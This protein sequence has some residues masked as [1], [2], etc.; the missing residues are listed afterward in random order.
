MILNKLKI[1]RLIP[2]ALLSCSAS[3]VQADEGGVSF[4]LPGQYSSLAAA[5][6]QQGW[7]L[8]LIYYH[9]SQ[10]AQ[11][12]QEIPAAGKVN[13]GLDAS[14]DLLLAVPSYAFEKPLWGA[15]ATVSM[16]GLYG[17]ASA[18]VD[19]SLSLLDGSEISGSDSGSLTA[20][21]DLYPSLTLRW[22]NGVHNTMAYGM[23]GVPVGSYN[24]NR[25]VNIGTNHWSAD[26]G[27]GYTY[28]N[29]TSKNEFSA[30]AGLTYNFENSDTDYQNGIDL[31]LDLG[32]SRF[33]TD[34]VH[35]GLVGYHFQQITGDSG[36]GAV[37]GDFKSKVS[38]VGPQ[39]GYMF[40]MGKRASY[41]NLKGYWEF[42]AK[43][44]PEGW[45]SWLTFSMPFSAS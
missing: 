32:A 31:H 41:I 28:F 19:A 38:G 17:H 9:G 8:A 30:V 34:Q 1:S 16:A 23:I 29:P 27:A 11:G 20:F 14:S 33:V 6:V 35:I 3:V 22:A 42:G 10:E 18:D 2:L 25:L 39:I 24:V 13:L 21:G 4:W 7:S 5:P 36:S 40:M 12:S 37:L 26:I 15:Q 45:N 43:N 44:R